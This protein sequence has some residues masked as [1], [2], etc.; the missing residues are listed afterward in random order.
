MRN[1]VSSMSWTEQVIAAHKNS[2]G[3]QPTDRRPRLIA[4]WEQYRTDGISKAV[5]EMALELAE[6][7][8]V[9]EIELGFSVLME[10]AVNDASLRCQPTCQT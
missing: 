9:N 1:T 2:L 8:N 6:Q 4:H 5:V 3:Q 7:G 10:L